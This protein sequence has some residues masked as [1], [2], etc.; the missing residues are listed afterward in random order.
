MKRLEIEADEWSKKRGNYKEGDP[1]PHDLNLVL[2]KEFRSR[3]RPAPGLK[4]VDIVTNA[5]R[6]AIVG[7]LKKQRWKRIPE[8]MVRRSGSAFRCTPCKMIESP[9]GCIR[10]LKF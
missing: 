6:R 9:I 4:L 5:T 3:R 8:L 10:T 2:K 1:K 7:N